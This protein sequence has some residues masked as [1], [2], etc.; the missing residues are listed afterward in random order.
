MKKK[1]NRETYSKR[2]TTTLTSAFLWNSKNQANLKAF[3]FAPLL[4]IWPYTVCNEAKYTTNSSALSEFLTLCTKSKMCTVIIITLR[5]IIAA[6]DLG[7]LVLPQWS[8]KRL[9]THWTGHQCITGSIKTNEIDNHSHA[10]IV[11]IQ[12]CQVSYM[13]LYG[14]WEETW[15][16]CAHGENIQMPH[17]KVAAELLTGNHSNHCS[18]AY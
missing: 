6:Q 13:Q 4:S 14:L 15:V 1:I 3:S 18:A 9:G 7:K 17:R 11:M 10:H 16:S 8:G 2:Q 5:V 12:S